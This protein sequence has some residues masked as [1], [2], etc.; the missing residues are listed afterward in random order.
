[1]MMGLIISFVIDVVHVQRCIEGR[2]TDTW[3][4]L[5][6]VVFCKLT[7][8]WWKKKNYLSGIANCFEGYEM[9]IDISKS[10]L[11]NHSLLNKFP[12]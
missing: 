3:V 12:I 8:I 5:Q 11:K 10:V 9:I 2:D 4:G 1:M 6:G 7:D